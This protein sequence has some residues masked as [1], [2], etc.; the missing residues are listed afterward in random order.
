M[1]W[2]GELRKRSELER[3][4]AHFHVHWQSIRVFC[5]R[6]D[7]A[8]WV[9]LTPTASRFRMNRKTLQSEVRVNRNTLQPEPLR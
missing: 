2:Q 6:D 8:Y 9:Q 5:W 4:A 3:I 1:A 7:S